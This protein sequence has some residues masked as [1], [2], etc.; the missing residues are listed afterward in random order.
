MG[1][2]SK[3]IY[4]VKL[5]NVWGKI[6]CEDYEVI[7]G[8]YEE[9]GVFTDK[10][11]FDKRYKAGMW[12]GKVRGVRRDGTFYLG[13]YKEVKEYLEKQ[14]E[15][16]L[17]VDPQFK[18][19]LDNKEDL[20]ENFVEVTNEMLTSVNCDLSPRYYQWRG[21]LKAYYYRRMIIEH[22]T[23]SGKSLTIAILINYI[24]HKNPNFKILVLVPRIDLVEQMTEDYVNAGINPKIIG[25]FTGEFKEFNEQIIISTW[26][27]M[28]TQNFLIKKFNVL[29]ADECHGLKAD[30]IRSVAENAINAEIRIGF[31]GT[32]PD[33]KAEQLLIKGVM[34][35]VGDT[36]T[37][38][39]L[40]EQKMIAIPKI[41]V[42]YLKYSNEEHK[43]INFLQKGLEGKEAY[44]I[45]Q[46]FLYEHDKRNE[47]IYKITKKFISRNQNILILVSKH[48]HC[49]I[50][51]KK[52]LE[53]GITPLIVTGKLK[54]IEE[55]TRI[56]KSLEETGGQVIM[57]TTGVY[58]TGISIKRLHAIILAAPGKS[59]IQ[60]LQTVGRGLRLDKRNDK[61]QLYLYDLADDFKY[62]IDS[63][64]ERMGYY[65]RNEFSVKIKEI[66]LNAEIPQ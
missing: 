63:L 24:I 37:V 3:D 55:R 52:L 53:K 35:F 38:A 50:I 26:Q 61:T 5:D 17:Q 45:E 14:S 60:T 39:E 56:R 7:S 66:D 51:K 16:T 43:K 29:I 10:Y 42:P 58:S 59:K 23:G 40:A 54:D 36:V 49:E 2:I 25:K 8:A 21:A 47:L 62:A 12:D 65:A 1:L 64:A 15:Y 11:F 34:G 44:V 6:S 41:H 19:V 18:I 48:A 9:F 20:K 32:L 22:C 27:S 31:T 46:M 28:H 33:S 13:L 30:V 57:A 4:I